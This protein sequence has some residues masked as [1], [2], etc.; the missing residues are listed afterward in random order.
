MEATETAVGTPQAFE[1]GSVKFKK[2]Y[3]LLTND[4]HAFNYPIDSV[5]KVGIL[6]GDLSKKIAIGLINRGICEAIPAKG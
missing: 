5:A 2:A 6:K 1:I 3:A 4:Y